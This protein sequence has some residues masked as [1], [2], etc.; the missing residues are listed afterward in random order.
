MIR[1]AGDRMDPLLNFRSPPELTK[2]I[3]A[4]AA[5]QED[6][7]SRSEAIRRLLKKALARR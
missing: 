7:P 2:R 5:A 1:A 3:D 4:W 6:K